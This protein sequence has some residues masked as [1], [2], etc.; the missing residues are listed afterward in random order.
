MTDGL[1]L[2]RSANQAACVRSRAK[3][4]FFST[5]GRRVGAQAAGFQWTHH[6]LLEDAIALL[7]AQVLL[8]NRLGDGLDVGV[9]RSGLR[10]QQGCRQRRT[11]STGGHTLN[12]R[13]CARGSAL[14]T[15]TQNK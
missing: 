14:G 10:L 11:C 12:W 3:R 7:R 4:G 13:D 6:Q 9:G 1:A 5:A 8:E 15:A 2:M